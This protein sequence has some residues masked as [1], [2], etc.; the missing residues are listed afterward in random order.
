MREEIEGRPLVSVAVGLVLGLVALHQL[1]ALVI[2]LGWIVICRPLA[3]RLGCAAAFLVGLIMAPRAPISLTASQ[4]IHGFGQ[5]VS[6]P[7][8]SRD[9]AGMIVRMEDGQ[10]YLLTDG[11]GT[12]LMLG[13]DVHIDG[14]AKPLTANQERLGSALGVSGRI[15]DSN[16]QVIAPAGFLLESANQWRLSFL[17]YCSHSLQAKDAGLLYAICFGSRSMIDT[18]TTENLKTGGLMHVTIASGMQV[19]LLAYLVLSLLRMFPIPRSIQ[20]GICAVLL[21]LYAVASGLNPAV[22]RVVVMTLLALAAFQVQREYDA[23]SAAAL[24]GIVYLLWSPQSIYRT[25][26]QLTF[27]VIACL[28]F[29]YNTEPRSKDGE[30]HKLVRFTYEYLRIS[31][32]ILVSVLPMVAYTF[33]EIPTLSIISNLMV[34]WVLPLIFTGGIIGYMAFGIWN[35]LGTAIAQSTLRPMLEWVDQVVNAMGQSHSSV[36]VPPF[37]GYWL[38]PYYVALA[39]ICRRIIVKP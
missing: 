8:M 25:G 15:N 1:F 24:S 26:F 28:S 3:A 33:G 11:P 37:S 2:L 7:R 36:S 16:V 10:E 34:G 18:R 27:V 14:V 30:K 32:L 12:G 29:L 39:L 5:V 23:P 22:V 38:I 4:P 31:V 35:D 20:V 6:V 9:V 17:D 21:L 13:T 19:C